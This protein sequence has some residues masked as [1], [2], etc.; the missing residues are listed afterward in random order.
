MTAVGNMLPNGDWAYAPADEGVTEPLAVPDMFGIEKV[1]GGGSWTRRSGDLCVG[2]GVGVVA[3][4]AAFDCGQGGSGGLI[5][6][7]ASVIG[8][9][10]EMMST[11][12]LEEVMLVLW[13]FASVGELPFC[14]SS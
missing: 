1:G 14:R 2:V 8:G 5:I 7:G 3:A 13:P 4:G 9:S 10:T 12:R 6:A 11:D